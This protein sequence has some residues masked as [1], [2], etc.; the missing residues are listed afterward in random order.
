LT[1]PGTVADRFPV[2]RK[3][4]LKQGQHSDFLRTQ[5]IPTA[6]ASR[7]VDLTRLFVLGFLAFVPWDTVNPGRE[8]LGGDLFSGTFTKT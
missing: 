8:I 4:L 2:D 5:P 6:K 3:P 1:P 7:K